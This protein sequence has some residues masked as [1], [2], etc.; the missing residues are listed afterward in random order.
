MYHCYG[1][2]Q[3]PSIDS[4]IS[5]LCPEIN[6]FEARLENKKS[7]AVGPAPHLQLSGRQKGAPF[8]LTLK[9]LSLF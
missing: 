8:W 5:S 6:R 1:I 4:S 3:L 2:D 9:Y 7:A